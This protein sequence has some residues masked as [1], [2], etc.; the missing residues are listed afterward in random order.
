MKEVFSGVFSDGKFLYTRNLREGVSVYGERLFSEQGVE[1]RHWSASTSKL[2]AGIQ[3]GLKDFPFREGSKV[4]YLGVGTGSTASHVSD[5]IGLEGLLVGVDVSAVMMRSFIQ[6][7]EQRGNV[8]PLLADAGRPE[9]YPEE[10]RKVKFDVLVQDVSQRNQAEIFLRN[11]SLLREKG[12]GLLS[13]KARSINVHGNPERVFREETL[14]LGKG[15]QV[16]QSVGLHPFEK[17]HALV[18][19]RKKD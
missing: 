15:F 14:K 5:I 12:S 16:L 7:S 9:A 13:I 4:L 11:A 18:L 1:F 17:A 3:K 19:C 10:L 2:A 6:L 8:A